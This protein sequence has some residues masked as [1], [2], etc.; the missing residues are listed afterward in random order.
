M[1]FSRA[2]GLRY[3]DRGEVFVEDFTVANGKLIAD[4]TLRELDLGDIVPANAKIVC[5]HTYAKYTSDGVQMY[6][7]PMGYTSFYT[8]FTV[9]TV[10]ANDTIR[11][12][13]NIPLIGGPKIQYKANDVEWTGLEI[14]VTGWFI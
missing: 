9:K 10:V 11:I 4:Y 14:D 3:V 2:A 1:F 13:V 6:I 8:A 12:W 5:L 7:L